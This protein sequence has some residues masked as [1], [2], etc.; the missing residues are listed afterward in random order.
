MIEDWHVR[1]SRASRIVRRPPPWLLASLVAAVGLT[2]TL[3]VWREGSAN[4]QATTQ[5]RLDAAADQVTQAIQRRMLSH[6]QVL[7]GGAALF[8]LSGDV[9]RS[10]WRTYVAG[11]KLEETSPG[12]LGVGFSKRIQADEL[13]AH[14][15]KVRAEGFP[16]YAV[17]PAGQRDEYH[18]II[19][20]EPFWGRNVRAF[21]YDM[22]T[23]PTRRAGLERARDT[24]EPV[25]TRRVTLVQEN[26][27]AVQPGF[28]L[29]LPVYR[30]GLPLGSIEERRHA[31]VGFVYSPF[32][33]HDLM[34]E[35]LA[36]LGRDV[37]IEVFDGDSAAPASALYATGV[38]G[39]RPEARYVSLRRLDF[40]GTT[41]T[42]RLTSL[43]AFEE[44]RSALESQFVL[45]G[46]LVL[47][48]FLTLLILSLMATRNRAFAM[49]KQMT[50]QLSQSEEHLRSVLASAADGILTIDA[51]GRVRTANPAA[52]AIFG[53]SGDRLRGRQVEALIDEHD[54][55]Q[56]DRIANEQGIGSSAVVHF[57]ATGKRASGE[58]FPLAV[59]LSRLT[60]AGNGCFTLMLRDVTEAK[61]TESILRLRER[62][63]DSSSNGV[64]ITDMRLPGQP[65][66]FV[67]PAFERITG[68][69]AGE[70]LGT[71]CR[72]LQGADTNQ[73]AIRELA[74]AIGEHR[75]TSVLLRNYR[76]DGSRFWNEL[77]IAPVFDDAGTCTHY[78]GIQ[79]DITSRMAAEA[80]LQR[81]TERLDA[82]F[83]LSPDGFVG[84][85]DDDRVSDVNAAFLTMT[86]FP[87]ERLMGIDEHE[88]DRLMES[89]CDPEQDYPPVCGDAAT[90]T[91]QTADVHQLLLIRPER[92][93][94]QRSIRHD[95]QGSLEKAVYFRDITRESEVD[96]LKSEF[97]STAAHELR[98]P[99][100]SIFGFSELLL[101]RKYDEAKTRE[102]LGTI[103]R[104]A[105]VLINLV[106][107]L[108]DLARIE[109]RAGKDFHPQRRD[110]RPTIDA[111]VS[112]LLIQGDARQVL[113]DLPETLPE[114]E[115]DAD[116]MALC[117]TNVLSNAYKYSPDGG[118]I[119]LTSCPGSHNG[120]QMLGIQ[121][122]DH[123]IGMSPEQSAR[124]FERF[125]RADP[126]G[127]IPGTGLGMSLVKEIM[128]QHGGRVDVASVKG[129]GTTV[130]LWLKLPEVVVQRLAA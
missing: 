75:A 57:E 123:G 95:R 87:V 59:S 32:R 129:M 49:A 128:D 85:G 63:L 15:T 41:W 46:G 38:S 7:R 5:V 31:L 120:C 91:G 93:V 122:R 53:L 103:N 35:V 16:A 90:R 117:L 113:I 9:S 52:E 80:A 54:Q 33:A 107:E 73:P 126:S 17:R 112:N 65:V 24:G 25:L 28:L 20:L 19:Y 43:P 44:S 118:S 47:T 108:L 79:N 88:F 13:Q 21:G 60:D 70:V 22:M 104:Q 102:L 106:N 115:F 105:S 71:N 94:L 116:K 50:G 40:N 111:A 72:I 18:S 56:L 30:N 109:A 76:K 67:N 96:R 8:S 86:G 61:L 58:S 119:E 14:E 37:A 68:Y 29:Y 55:W 66:I 101:K 3:W 51:D 36:G 23:E 48:A 74:E 124:I 34:N 100:A 69:S 121:V 77:S 39:S 127:N 42:I 82:I 97:L 4:N 83:A 62:A 99:M 78:V 98:T 45:I 10:Q 26:T 84:F 81:R 11:L 2:V 64:V 92:R 125:Y 27:Q 114:L 12:V 6:E 1:L 110:I 89:L 130:T